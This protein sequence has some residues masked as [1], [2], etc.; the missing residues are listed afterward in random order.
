MKNTVYKLFGVRFLSVLLGI[1]AVGLFVGLSSC[2]DMD[3]W[4]NVPEEINRFVTKYFPGSGYQSFTQTSD[5]YKVII[6]NGPGIT[7]DAGCNWTS[8]NGYGMPLPQIFLFDCMPPELYQYLEET[9]NLKDVF[10][11]KIENKV[12]VVKTTAGEVSYNTA[13]GELKGI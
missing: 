13:T 11:V 2:S 3:K 5:G 8:V 4:D 6:K 12:Y 10:S 7:F 9:D 1:T